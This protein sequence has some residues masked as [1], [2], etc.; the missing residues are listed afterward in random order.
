[1]ASLLNGMYFI[2]KKDVGYHD[3]EGLILSI[4]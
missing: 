4:N 3:S 1:M 2:L